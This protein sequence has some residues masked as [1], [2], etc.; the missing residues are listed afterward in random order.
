M[1]TLHHLNDS[2]SQR[3]LWL[4]EELGAPYEMKRYQR[5]QTVMIVGSNLIE[6]FFKLKTNCKTKASFVAALNKEVTALEKLPNVPGFD[7][8]FRATVSAV[9]ETFLSASQIQKRV[10]PDLETVGGPV[11]VAVISKGDGFVWIKRKHYFEERINP[12]FR[13]RYVEQ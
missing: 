13:L 1:L 7:D 3:I 5:D 11:D 12:S 4:L 6:A 10:N 8:A 9:A 2:R